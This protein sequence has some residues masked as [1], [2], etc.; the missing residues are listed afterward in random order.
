[1]SKC[2]HG[3]FTRAQSCLIRPPP[4]AE[5]KSRITRMV[6]DRSETDFRSQYIPTCATWRG[7]AEEQS[8]E[9]SHLERETLTRLAIP[10][11][12]TPPRINRSLPLPICTTLQNPAPP[13]NP[14]VHTKR[15]SPTISSCTPVPPGWR[16]DLRYFAHPNQQR[17]MNEQCVRV[18]ELKSNEGNCAVT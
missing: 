14:L 10:H 2:E 7:L 13:Q 3:A 16:V 18:E 9:A 4:R 1:M 15:V 17:Q 6:L 8:G 12:T 11:H 5:T